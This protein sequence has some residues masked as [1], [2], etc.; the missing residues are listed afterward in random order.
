MTKRK[1]NH[2]KDPKHSSGALAREVRRRSN[3]SKKM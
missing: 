3:M 2:E 1:M